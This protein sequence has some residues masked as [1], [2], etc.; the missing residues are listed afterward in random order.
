[1]LKKRVAGRLADDR[2]TAHV[3]LNPAF[4]IEFRPVKTG[5]FSCSAFAWSSVRF[6]AASSAGPSPDPRM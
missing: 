2:V 1:M 4:A 5:E 3:G 6:A